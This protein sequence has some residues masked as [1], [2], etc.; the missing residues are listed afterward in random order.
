MYQD[1]I[2]TQKN[3]LL[4]IKWLTEAEKFSTSKM[5]TIIVDMIGIDYET[6]FDYVT[7]F[8]YLKKAAIA[9]NSMAADSLARMYIYGHG[10]PEDEIEAYAWFSVAVAQGL[11]FEDYQKTVESAR[12]DLAVILEKEGKIT[13]GKALARKYYQ[14]Y[15][16]RQN[17]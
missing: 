11:D 2:G 9:G 17:T 15:V 8:H 16:S 5:Q 13:E 6:M 10:V 3:L 7:A 14:L 12:N 1:G 4:A